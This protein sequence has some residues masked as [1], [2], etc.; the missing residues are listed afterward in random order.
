MTRKDLYRIKN[1]I[2]ACAE[3]SN[4]T[5]IK[6]AHTLAIIY[7]EIMREIDII[8]KSRKKSSPMYVAYKEKYNAIQL[9]HSIQKEDGTLQTI[10]GEVV[11]K[12]PLRY[13]TRITALKEEFKDAV[14]AQTI[15][16]KELDK[17]LDE[18]IT[19]EFTKIPISLFPSNVTV[20][21]MIML[22]PVILK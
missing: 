18:S 15:I 4:E 22:N 5:D 1:G 3:I 21:I 16:D 10:N 19:K 12:E 17:F 20:G 13:N 2:E 14:D 6:F 8:E 7:D 11:I 9:E